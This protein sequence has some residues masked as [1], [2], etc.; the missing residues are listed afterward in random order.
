MGGQQQVPSSSSSGKSS[1]IHCTGEW[2][3]LLVPSGRVRIIFLLLEFETPFQVIRPSILLFR[4]MFKPSIIWYL[5]NCRFL[6]GE[7]LAFRSTSNLTANLYLSFRTGFLVY[8]L[9][10][11]TKWY[12]NKGPPNMG[13]WKYEY[14]LN[15]WEIDI[16]LLKKLLQCFFLCSCFSLL[17]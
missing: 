4:K 17:H 12:F 9:L 3:G 6:F 10:D 8:S 5:L 1:S 14:L 7:F 11:I 2:L 15:I 16:E 13:V